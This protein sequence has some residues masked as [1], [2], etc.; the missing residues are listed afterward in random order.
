VDGSDAE[1]HRVAVFDAGHTHGTIYSLPRDAEFVR[2]DGWYSLSLLPTDQLWLAPLLADR[3]AAL[4]HSA[5]VILNGQG[6]LFIG[7]SEAGKSTTVTLLTNGGHTQGAPLE[8]EILCDDRNIVRRW[9]EGWRV[10]GTWSHGDVENVSSASAP[11]RAI[12]FLHQDS[13]NAIT[14]LTDRKESRKLLLGTLIKP[15]VTAEWWQKELHVLERL[16][17]EVPCYTMHFDK[18]GAIVR[19]LLSVIR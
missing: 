5:A 17:N 6:L 16:V 11:L 8:V 18:S 15:M 3:N 7:H 12:L 1:L 4:M 14:L 13:R 10:H 2:T 19:E 9:D